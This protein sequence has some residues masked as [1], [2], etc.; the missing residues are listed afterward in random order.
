VLDMKESDS[1]ILPRDLCD[2]VLKLIA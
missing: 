2:A 1:F